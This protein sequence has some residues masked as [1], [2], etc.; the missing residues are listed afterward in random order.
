MIKHT[1]AVTN[2]M[3]DAESDDS[4]QTLSQAPCHRSLYAEH[5]CERLLVQSSN[6]HIESLSNTLV[7]LIWMCIDNLLLEL[8]TWP[9]NLP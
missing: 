5:Q 4:G 1:P 9:S 7:T 2:R 3:F 8:A 6:Q